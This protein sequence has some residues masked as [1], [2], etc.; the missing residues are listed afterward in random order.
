M[1]NTARRQKIARALVET[2]IEII[3]AVLTVTDIP[4]GL[5]SARFKAVLI[6]K[7]GILPHINNMTPA[8]RVLLNV[9]NKLA[10]EV[11]TTNDFAI[12]STN[13]AIAD[14]PLVPP[15]DTIFIFQNVEIIALVLIN[16]KQ[17]TDGR[18]DGDGTQ[19]HK[20][21]FALGEV[22]SSHDVVNAVSMSRSAVSVFGTGPF[23]ETA[24]VKDAL[25]EL[26]GIK[27]A[28]ST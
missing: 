13:R 14:I 6:L 26:L 9:A 8:I 16:P 2:H 18:L 19:G 21:N 4:S 7:I 10:Y 27:I 24:F 5:I 20:R 3:D 25:D 23:V 22:I 15:S 12:N 28:L 11:V 17:L 1:V